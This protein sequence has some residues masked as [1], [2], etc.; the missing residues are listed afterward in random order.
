VCKQAAQLLRSAACLHTNQSRS[1]LNHLVNLQTE[2]E[3]LSSRAIV[4]RYTDSRTEHEVFYIHFEF[5]NGPLAEK[6]HGNYKVRDADFIIVCLGCLLCFSA[7]FFFTIWCEYLYSK[8]LLFM[9]LTFVMPN[10]IWIMIHA[11]FIVRVEGSSCQ[12]Y[13]FITFHGS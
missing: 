3:W 12:L 8:M 2:K 5:L 6:V 4:H 1:Y 13:C 10:L 11:A 7:S 9:T